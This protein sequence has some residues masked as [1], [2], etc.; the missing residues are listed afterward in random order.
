MPD[1]L[2]RFLFGLGSV[3]FW[4]LLWQIVISRVNRNLLIKIPLPYDTVKKF[5]ADIC[6]ASFWNAVGKSMLS[7]ICGFTFAV[8]LGTL[9]GILSGNSDFFKVLTHP[10]VHMIRSVPVAAFIVLAWLWIPSYILPSFISF[11]MVFPIVWNSVETGILS[12]DNKLVEMAR[13]GGLSN[14]CIIRNIKIPTTLPF[15][16]N[17]CITGLGFAWKSGVAAEVICNPTG[18]IGALLRGAKNTLDYESV[19]SLILTIVI[20]S[21]LLEN[22]LK[23][24]WR[25]KV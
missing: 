4:V 25:Q 16:R 19:F 9:C 21:L 2:K 11:L 3:L 15:L 18:S 7:I 5:A 23:I 10:V 22:I 6:T 17:A 1:K 13:V 20:L 24:L 12:V 8:I 14:A